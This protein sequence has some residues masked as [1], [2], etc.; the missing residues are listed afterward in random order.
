MGEFDNNTFGG[1]SE[2]ARNLKTELLAAGEAIPNLKDLGKE[3]T[4]VM[5]SFT[6]QTTELSMGL[7]KVIKIQSEFRDKI[8]DTIKNITFLEE[9]NKRL[10][11][12]FGLN[13]I[14]ADKLAK[15]L[16]NVAVSF[17]I[18]DE[19]IFDYAENLKGLTNGFIASTKGVGTFS[20]KLLNTQRV[21][22]NNLQLSSQAAEGYE[23]YASTI[24]DSGESA[25]AAQ[26]KLSQALGSELNLDPV[27]IMRDLTEEIGGM[28]ADLQMRYSR[29]PGSLELAVLKSRALGMNMEKLNNAGEN[30]LNIESSIGQEMEYQL[31]SGR[32]LTTEDGKSLTNAY[33]MATLEGNANKQAELM[34]RL[35]TDQGDV[36]QKNL[37]ARKKAAELMGT[38]EATIARAIQKQKILTKLGATNLMALSADKMQPEI[39]KLRKRYAGNEKAQK[40]IDELL[41]ATETR[42]TA[43]RSE[44]YLKSI[45]SKIMAGAGINVGA[46]STKVKGGTKQ[47]GET[48][49]MFSGEQFQRVI[50]KVSLLGETFKSLEAPITKLIGKIPVFGG[51]LSTAISSVTGNIPSFESTAHKDALIMNDGIIQFHQDD[52]LMRV[53][54]S[55]MIAGTN[56]NGN[57]QLARAINGGGS[58]IDYNKLAMAIVSAMKYAKFEVKADNLFQATAQ[59]NRRRF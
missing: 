38:D 46:V 29:I 52:K 25:L 28:T 7:G 32:R 13:S 18:G 36:L 11:K 40:Q 3:L 31:L 30:L 5:T 23:L 33:R 54:D 37:Y 35:V 51:K 34:N 50:G 42:T 55:T 8:V 27:Q 43:E 56:V 20:K 2:Q 47:F 44:D 15:N 19:K 24:A 39:E 21:I 58:S 45:D 26:M 10:N 53:N 14:A 1:L 16:R 17:A 4:A 49:Q 48:M 57:K 41:T 22:V 59:N 6:D 12:T 9:S